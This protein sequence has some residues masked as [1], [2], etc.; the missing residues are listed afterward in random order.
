MKGDK[1]NTLIDIDE[2]EDPK[3]AAD[4]F[5]NI[6]NIDVNIEEAFSQN[7]QAIQIQNF[8][9]LGNLS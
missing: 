8:S 1:G 4:Y 2:Y 3:E 6:D 9:N 7:Q 5:D